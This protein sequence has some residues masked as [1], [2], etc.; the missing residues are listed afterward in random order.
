MSVLRNSISLPLVVSVL[1][2]YGCDQKSSNKDESPA[3]DQYQIVTLDQGWTGDERL[4][5]YNT[6]QGSQ[7]IPFAWFLALEQATSDDLFR[8]SNNMRRLGYLPQEPLAG[9]NPHGLPIGFVR[10]DDIEPLVSAS[11]MAAR[12]SSG[13]GGSLSEYKEWLG[14]TCAAC[15]TSEVN[16]S[17]HSLRI[18]GGPPLS[19]FQSFIEELSKSLQATA[20]NDDKLTR[21]AKNVLAEGGYNDIE[22]QRLKAEINQFRSWIDNYIELNYAGLS[23]PY[24]YGRLDAFG[25]ILNRVTA[26]FI[27]IDA[28]AR[29]ANAPV[30]FPFLW[31]S[32]Q[33][34]WVQW[35]GSANNHIGRNIGE[36]LGVFAHTIVKTSNPQEQFQSS[37]KILNL[38]RLEQLM[39][40]LEAP[41]WTAPLPE[42]DQ[43]KA[44][45]GKT[46]FAGNCVICHGIRDDNGQFPM[47]A[48]NVFGARFIEIKM[49]PLKSIGTDPLMAM[50]FVN[51]AY[52]V[53][54]GVMRNFLPEPYK[55]KPTVPRAVILSSVVGKVIARQLASLNPPDPNEWLLALAGYHVPEARGGP[56]PPNLVAY[57][58]RPLNG[59]WA[60]APFLHNGSVSSLYQ[61]LLPDTE[62]AA[63]FYVGS[64]DFDATNI[65]FESKPGKSNFLFKTVDDQGKPIPGNG[66]HG[67]SGKYYTEIKGEDGQ[68]RNY[69]DQ[70]RY[71]L[72]EYMKTL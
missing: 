54:P 57:K 20:E 48:P 5:F 72:I 41:I 71:Q 28:N 3:D 23:T 32:S 6:S 31:N 56:A 50:N 21:F 67:H 17:K 14:F 34:G 51:P 9:T 18:D 52:D 63:S 30:S 69:T 8:D 35:N 4:D 13:T 36:V 40:R 59:I 33:L 1:A 46:L 27:D 49:I 43:D 25:A 62:R 10:D 39:S 7:L 24:G 2:L 66:K 44:A 64:K 65:G 70:E 68:W 16:F 11:L 38:D 22:K 61:L 19:D 37:A 55:S 58:A 42:I 12:L 47:T 15:H 60:T 45:Q 53:D 26:S 29:P